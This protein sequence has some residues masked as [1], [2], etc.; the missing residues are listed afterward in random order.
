MANG[1]LWLAERHLA[2]S[3]AW[4]FWKY[5]LGVLSEGKRG[6]INAINLNAGNTGIEIQGFEDARALDLANE[7]RP[8]PEM[9][10][11]RKK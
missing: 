10:N 11:N 7:K 2:N 3:K 1:D 9:K 5:F 6:I 8:T 4:T